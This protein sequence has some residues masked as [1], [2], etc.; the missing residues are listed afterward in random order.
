MNTKRLAIYQVLS[1]EALR[2]ERRVIKAGKIFLEDNLD[3]EELL[4][5]VYA[6]LGGIESFYNRGYS[7]QVEIIPEKMVDKLPG[8]NLN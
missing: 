2:K 8:A 5:R 7:L 4:D 1:C 3:L 6:D